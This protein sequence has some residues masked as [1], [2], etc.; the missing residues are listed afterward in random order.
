MDGEH[1][2]IKHKCAINEDSS[3]HEEES[4][5]EDPVQLNMKETKLSEEEQTDET[6][7]NKPEKKVTFKDKLQLPPGEARNL[8]WT[9]NTHPCRENIVGHT[10]SEDIS[11]KENMN[12]C[13]TE[14]YFSD[15]GLM[16][17]I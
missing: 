17:A 11:M 9:V 6:E 12:W 3:T 4:E 14:H 13:T 7:L 5:E 8:E 2:E 1:T 16:T 10:R 15:Y